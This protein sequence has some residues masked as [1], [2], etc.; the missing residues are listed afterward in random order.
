[1]P[2]RP[3]ILLITGDHLNWN[4]I[5]DRSI[6][7]TPNLNRIARDGSAFRALLHRRQP[8]LPLARRPALRR[9]PVA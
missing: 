5:C 9:L 3:N 8:L 6:C 4:A 2:D 7:R 1:M